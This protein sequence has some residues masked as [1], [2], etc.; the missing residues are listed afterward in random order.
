MIKVTIS[1]YSKKFSIKKICF[2]DSH[3]WFRT[4]YQDKNG[5]PIL[6]RLD[7]SFKGSVYTTA[8][9]VGVD[10]KM[11]AYRKHIRDSENQRLTLEDYKLV[12]DEF[13]LINKS[14]TELCDP[15]NP[16]DF[17]QSCYDGKGNLH[18]I[19]MDSEGES[20]RYDS[21]GREIDDSS[22]SLKGFET[23]DHV[24]SQYIEEAIKN[25]LDK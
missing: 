22:F 2:T 4:T 10:Y 18:Y 19:S 6:E 20:K 5:L 8:I 7:E 11:V 25:S 16:Y 21:E 9:L 24:E 3:G 13:I 15:N 14:V 12:G 17:K 1:E 23:I